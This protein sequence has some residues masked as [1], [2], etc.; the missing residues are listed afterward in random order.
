[1][2]IFL[3]R[4]GIIHRDLS[5]RNVFIGD[6]FLVKVGNFGMTHE[7][8]YY[9]ITERGHYIQDMAPECIFEEKYSVKSDV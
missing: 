6:N 5:T 4:H 9:I 8:R 2:Q 3:N 1:M 7:G